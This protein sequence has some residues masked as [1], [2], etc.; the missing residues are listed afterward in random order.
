MPALLL[1]VPVAVALAWVL[2]SGGNLK[3]RER[4]SQPFAGDVNGALGAGKTRR[5][6]SE[7]DPWKRDELEYERVPSF[8]GGEYGDGYGP[9]QG[10]GGDP[11]MTYDTP[12]ATDTTLLVGGSPYSSLVPEGGSYDDSGYYYYDTPQQF[13]DAPVI[14]LTPEGS[15]LIDLPT[16]SPSQPSAPT[17]GDPGSTQPVGGGSGTSPQH[18]I[19]LE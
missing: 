3:L 15:P 1:G 12:D 4:L 16:W 10:E 14:G 13:L 17:V 9:Q 6:G 8:T 2:L 5:L 19:L 11:G 7:E 18:P